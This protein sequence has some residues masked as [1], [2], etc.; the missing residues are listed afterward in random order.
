MK[1]E[2]F[3][4]YPEALLYLVPNLKLETLNFQLETYSEAGKMSFALVPCPG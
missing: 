2:D 1:D 4:L 3:L